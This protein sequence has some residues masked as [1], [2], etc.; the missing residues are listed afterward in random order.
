[1]ASTYVAEIRKIR[2]KGPY[3]L[4]GWSF[5]GYVAFEMANMMNSMSERV[6]KLIL[7]D[8]HPYGAAN[9]YNFEDL[10]ID[11]SINAL[12]D[13]APGMMEDL[14]MQIIREDDMDLLRRRMALFEAYQRKLMKTFRPVPYQGSALMFASLDAKKGASNDSWKN[15]ILGD[16]KVYNV[17]CG[18]YHMMDA[19]SLKEIGPIISHELSKS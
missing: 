19:S 1:M 5:G 14:P 9:E 17:N 10:C 8:A 11:E 4:L 15:N 6:N 13:V 3:N 18:H 2:P 7:L 12:M 16:V